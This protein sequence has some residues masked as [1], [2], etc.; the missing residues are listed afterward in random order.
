[1]SDLYFKQIEV[2][3]EKNGMCLFALD[4]HGRVWSRRYAMSMETIRLSRSG[5]QTWELMPM[6]DDT[7]TEPRP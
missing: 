4:G 7:K 2:V 5:W 3:S 6:P 1:M